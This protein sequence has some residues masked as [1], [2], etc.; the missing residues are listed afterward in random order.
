MKVNFIE[1]TYVDFHQIKIGEVFETDGI[2]Y[3]KVGCEH[4]FDLFNNLIAMQ[5]ICSFC[6]RSVD[7]LRSLNCNY[8]QICDNCSQQRNIAFTCPLCES[9]ERH[10]VETVR[11]F[12]NF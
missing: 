11:S 7:G 10:M 8:H 3:L 9:R 4:A 6:G 1:T 2:V 12:V 5:S